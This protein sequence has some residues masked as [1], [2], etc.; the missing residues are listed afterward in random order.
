MAKPTEIRLSLQ[1]A[2]EDRLHDIDT[3]EAKA[4][5]EYYAWKQPSAERK[6]DQ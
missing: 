2:K 6:G 1:K 4:I 3:Y 5:G